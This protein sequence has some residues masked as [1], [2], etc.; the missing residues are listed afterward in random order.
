MEP[1][2]YE[3]LTD[4]RRQDLVPM[5]MPGHKRNPAFV[6]ENPYGID[7][8]EV[9]GM[10][11]LHHPEG[12]IRRLMDRVTREYH[13]E[14]SYLLVNGS[15]G[16]ILSAIAACCRHGDRIVLARN[17]H[18]SVYHAIRLLELRPVYIY[19]QETGGDMKCLGIPGIVSEQTVEQALQTY[20]DVRCVI[21]TSPTYEGIVSPIREIA[22]V[23]GRYGV[24]F[25]VD[26]AH[27]A[28]FN[29]HKSFPDTA[30]E[31]GADLVVESLHKTL[32][33]LTQT[34]VLH[35]RFDR[36]S[37]ERLEWSLQTFQSSSPSYVLMA[38]IDRCFAY[39][40]R[41]GEAAFEA[42]VHNLRQFEEEMKCLNGLY[43]FDSPHKERSKIVIATDR[44]EL[45]G[46][47]LAE[48]L[49][50]Q[51][52]IET[53]MNGG[54][55]CIAMTSVCDEPENFR[56]LGAALREIDAGLSVGGTDG[57]AGREG[58][59]SGSLYAGPDFRYIWQEQKRGM[60][61]YEAAFCRC[62]RIRLEEA[63][64]R[65]TAADIIP[66]PPGIPLLVRGELFSGE[67]IRM[68]RAGIDMG[69]VIYGVEDD[70]VNVIKGD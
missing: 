43:L 22:A 45:S 48:R 8:T 6:M 25:I 21:L 55:Y 69:Y 67:M 39:I 62:E 34:G 61:S 58:V 11:D 59:R 37:K 49:L 19:P 56:R 9:T 50:R 12:M 1:S 41:E 57:A 29:W 27:G 4:Y 44:T 7:V 54:D 28:H 36:V 47:Q 63:E 60:Y 20:D 31:E 42:Y 33:S 70:S 32:P 15:T 5:H 51:Y 3:T 2:L 38:G 14:Q 18:K 16:G 35:A 26:E 17:C 46:R 65:M 52:R 13:S 66:Y 30:L 53:E 24:P 68:I 64:D 40:E 23:T 10:D